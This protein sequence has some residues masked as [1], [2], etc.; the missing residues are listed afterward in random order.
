MSS[1]DRPAAPS[2]ASISDALA[3]LGVYAE[4]PSG[5]DL[6]QQAVAA[7]GELVLAAALAN[8]LYGAAIGTGMLAEGHMLVEV[9]GTEILLEEVSS[10]TVTL[11]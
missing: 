6:E 7:G 9:G 2:V 10:F 5:D 11:P 3:A 4:V 1:A 8:A